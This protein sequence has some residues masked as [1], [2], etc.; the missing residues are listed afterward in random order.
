VIFIADIACS[1]VQ[2][3][4]VDERCML[5][6]GHC[7][8]YVLTSFR[9]FIMSTKDAGVAAVLSQLFQLHAAYGITCQAADFMEVCSSDV[10]FQ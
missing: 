2:I 10:I 6:E 1:I 3:Y 9:E 4:A 5:F 8:V 7:E